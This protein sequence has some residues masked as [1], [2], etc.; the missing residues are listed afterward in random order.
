MHNGFSC[1]NRTTKKKYY[2]RD[3]YD[4]YIE[5]LT[6]YTKEIIIIHLKDDDIKLVSS[7][8]STIIIM[9]Q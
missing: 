4:E 6:K 1:M 7:N 2:L 3:V 5:F 9:V 8:D